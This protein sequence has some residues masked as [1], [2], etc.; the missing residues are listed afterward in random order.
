MPVGSMDRESEVLAQVVE[1]VDLHLLRLHHRA[2]ELLH[3]VQAG[4]FL[5]RTA[6]CGSRRRGGSIISA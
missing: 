3:V 1:L 2:G 4:V 6:P 5:P